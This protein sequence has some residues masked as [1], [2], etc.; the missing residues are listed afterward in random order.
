MELKELRPG[1]IVQGINTGYCY[2]EELSPSRVSGTSR[3]DNGSTISTFDSI[4]QVLPLYISEDWLL[5]FGFEKTDIEYEY[6][7]DLGSGRKIMAN[8][9][10]FAGYA[11]NYIVY[12]YQAANQI[13]MVHQLQNLYFAVT[14]EEITG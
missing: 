10:L 13:S 11:C 2:I 1:N 14:G 3:G 5:E 7:L 6:E 12:G 4:T 9:L 8:R